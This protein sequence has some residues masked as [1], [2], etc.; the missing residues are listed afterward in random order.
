MNDL[1]V[2][3]AKSSQTLSEYPYK[4]KKGDWVKGYYVYSKNESYML[5]YYFKDGYDDRFCGFSVKIDEKTLCRPTG[6]KIND[7][8][9]YENDKIKIKT[10]GFASDLEYI[11]EWNY[12]KYSW[13]CAPVGRGSWRPYL[14]TILDT[15][16]VEII[17]NKYDDIE[18]NA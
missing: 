12:E 1:L 11:V 15:H 3:K 9:L 8:M 14:E 17:G 2:C 16:D 4:Y 18:G 10:S 6:K 13:E 5:P 7:V